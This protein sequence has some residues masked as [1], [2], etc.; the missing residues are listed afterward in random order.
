MAALL[1]NHIDESTSD[2]EI[3]EFLVKY[4]FPSFDHIERV[5]STG[6]RPA[7]LVRFNECSA[8]ELRDLL[9]RI[10]QVFWKQHTISA[11]VMREP[12]E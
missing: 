11:L 9:P 1:I 3:R 4:G 12:L 6:S 10:H 7:V 5:P 2:E 8:P